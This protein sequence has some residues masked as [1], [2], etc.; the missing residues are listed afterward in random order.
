MQYPVFQTF[1]QPTGAS[2]AAPAFVATAN[3]PIV[4][5]QPAASATATATTGAPQVFQPFVQQ[6]QQPFVGG[7]LVVGPYGPFRGAVPRLLYFNSRGLAEYSRLMLAEGGFEFED[8]RI[9]EFTAE[10]K[11]QQPFGQLP[12]LEMDGRRIPESKAI[13]WYI[14]RRCGFVGQNIDDQTQ[15]DIVLEVIADIRQ[16]LSPLYAVSKEGDKEKLARMK[17][18]FVKNELGKWY[19]HLEGLLLR[20]PYNSNPYAPTMFFA[21]STPTIADF[22]V[23]DTLSTNS[24]GLEHD[25]KKLLNESYPNLGRFR[26]SFARLP[27]VARWIANHPEDYS[28]H[29][30]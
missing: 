1:R 26:Q 20:N 27:G 3:A 4:S 21:G 18:E 29:R 13:A 30:V 2:V 16:K 17:D 28:A 23:F 9:K 25:N 7:K 6:Q 15:I 22:A 12:V 19:G 5:A 10:M 14:A 8:V 11:A 24:Y